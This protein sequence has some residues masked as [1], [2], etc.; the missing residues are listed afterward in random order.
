[1]KE[2]L[3]ELGADPRFRMILAAAKRARPSI[4]AWHPGMDPEEWKYRSGMQAG[5]D[6]ALTF[7]GVSATESMDE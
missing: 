1:M 5:F 7:F 2:Y 3:L 6:S 4:P